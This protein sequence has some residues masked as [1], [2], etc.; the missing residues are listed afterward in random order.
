MKGGD[1]TES[2]I[3]SNAA[4]GP[5][6]TTKEFRL[7]LNG[8]S[9]ERTAK[10]NISWDLSHPIH[11]SIPYSHLNNYSYESYGFIKLWTHSAFLGAPK[12]L[13]SLDQCTIHLGKQKLWTVALDVWVP[14]L[15]LNQIHYEQEVWCCS[16]TETR[17]FNGSLLDITLASHNSFHWFR[18][19]V[20]FSFPM[21]GG[22]ESAL[23]LKIKTNFILKLEDPNNYKKANTLLKSSRGTLNWRLVDKN[24]GLNGNG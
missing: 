18:F 1:K 11:A 24:A 14:L 9:K 21:K 23:Q 4:S 6:N 5:L 8:I 20:C 3:F 22:T 16:V 2:Y 19:T 10:G 17:L 12:L 7:C 15:P 13:R